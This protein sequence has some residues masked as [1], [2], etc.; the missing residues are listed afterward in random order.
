VITVEETRVVKKNIF[1]SNAMG[2]ACTTNGGEEEC[3]QN[4]GGKERRK[5]TI[6]KTKT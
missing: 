6:R 4:I 3:I 1:A 2:K 5:E